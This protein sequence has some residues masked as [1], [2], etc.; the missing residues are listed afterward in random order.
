M[1]DRHRSRPSFVQSI[2]HSLASMDEKKSTQSVTTPSNKDWIAWT[3]Y[4]NYPYLLSSEMINNFTPA[5]I[6]VFG[7][8]GVHASVIRS[9]TSQALGFTRTLLRFSSSPQTLRRANKLF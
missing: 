5:Y 1:T 3:I 2:H 4:S 7:L 8:D 9:T 6:Q